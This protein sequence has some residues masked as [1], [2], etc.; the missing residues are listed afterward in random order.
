VVGR[1]RGGKGNN[2]SSEEIREPNQV[3]E[4]SKIGNILKINKI[5][6]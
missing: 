5:K 6:K 1:R 2:R 4:H 3:K